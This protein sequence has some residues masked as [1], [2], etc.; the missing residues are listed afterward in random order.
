LKIT[1]SVVVFQ[2]LK[3]TTA[4]LS[5]LQKL[6][7]DWLFEMSQEGDLLLVSVRSYCVALI[8]S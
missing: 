1:C 4:S 3:L 8:R 7:N 5:K 2:R 6:A